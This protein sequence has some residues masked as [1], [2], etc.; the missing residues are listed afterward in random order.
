MFFFFYPLLFRFL[1]HIFHLFIFRKLFYLAPILQSLSS[2]KVFQHFS[3]CNRL[4]IVISLCGLVVEGMILFMDAIWCTVKV[5]V[6]YVC[7]GKSMYSLLCIVFY[8]KK[9]EYKIYEN[10]QIEYQTKIKIYPPY[11]SLLT[12]MSVGFAYQRCDAKILFIAAFQLLR[13]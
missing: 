11:R 12:Y 10:I 1:L 9:L 7:V 5:C 8:G 2:D 6:V 4:K 13:F 3:L